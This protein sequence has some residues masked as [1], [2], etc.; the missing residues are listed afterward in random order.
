RTS[1]PTS[2]ARSKRSRGRSRESRGGSAP[3]PRP[4]PTPSP[5]APHR[6]PGDDHLGRHGVALARRRDAYR[7]V[8]LDS[9]QARRRAAAAEGDRCTEAEA[10]APVKKILASRMATN[11]LLGVLSNGLAR[12]G[13]EVPAD[14]MLVP[15]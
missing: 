6:G 9:L 4:R 7:R 3:R 11:A 5:D 10:V 12:V 15:V 8:L 13:F 14:D 2:R 1:R